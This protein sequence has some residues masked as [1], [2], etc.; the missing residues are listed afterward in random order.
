MAADFAS[1]VSGAL[2]Q[3]N[4]LT[5]AL[6][7]GNTPQQF[8]SRLAKEPYRSSIPWSK[9]WVFWGDER[10]VPKDHVESNFRM[11]SEA[12]LQYVVEQN[13]SSDYQAA[14]IKACRV[15]AGLA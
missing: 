15:K 3:Q 8:Y 7:G 11:A 4:R 2:S 1:Y 9:L 5:I 10:C 6:A 14:V 12:L 13:I